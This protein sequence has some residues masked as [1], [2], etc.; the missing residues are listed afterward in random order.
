MS[1]TYGACVSKQRALEILT[2]EIQDYLPI[3]KWD[4]YE[5]TVNRV[6][7][8]FA[9]LDAVKPILYKAQRR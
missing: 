9:K 1:K 8:E 6:R 5:M 2:D 3:E 7:Y 4:E